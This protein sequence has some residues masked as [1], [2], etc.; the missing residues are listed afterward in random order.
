M[1]TDD[2]AT[3]DALIRLAARCAAREWN[4]ATSG[5]FSAR[6]SG[7]Q[8]AITRTGVDKAR[9]TAADILTLPLGAPP[10]SQA[11]AEAPLHL[12]VLQNTQARFVAHVHAPAVT[13]LSTAVDA[14][15]RFAG[16]EMLKGLAGI[17]THDVQVD[18]PVLDNSQDMVTLAAELKLPTAVP[19]FVLRGHGLYAWGVDAEQAFRHVET[20]EY[21]S[22]LELESRRIR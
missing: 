21:L 8:V 11:S 3:I 13:V 4:V 14:A 22:G 20:L 2:A 16:W 18:L 1:S 17:S 19:G 9:L 12:R 15:I 6:L 7:Q 5:N 10:P